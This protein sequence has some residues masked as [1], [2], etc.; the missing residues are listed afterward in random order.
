MSLEK[1]FLWRD[2]KKNEKI[3]LSLAILQNF[4]N[5]S[6][7]LMTICEGIFKKCDD[8]HLKPYICHGDKL[9]LFAWGIFITA[10][11]LTTLTS[12][13]QM[14]KGIQNNE[15]KNLTVYAISTVYSFV[16]SIIMCFFLITVWTIVIS[17]FFSIFFFYSIVI[18]L[19]LLLISESEND[20]ANRPT[21]ASSSNFD[22]LK[23]KSDATIVTAI[24]IMFSISLSGIIFANDKLGKSKD[25]ILF[26]FGGINLII[27]ALNIFVIIMLTFLV[28]KMKSI[29]GFS[30][31]FK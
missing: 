29:S 28:K 31:L 15:R 23:S 1:I 12:T 2:V 27:V 10:I 8:F 5:F 7:A 13:F 3:F 4:L 17:A 24:Q 16:L 18:I 25:R 6:L 9:D 30:G 14:L 26:A 22:T 11:F 20:Q 19:N 21:E